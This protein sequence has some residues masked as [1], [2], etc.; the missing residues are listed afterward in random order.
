[1]ASLLTEQLKEQQTGIA[2]AVTQPLWLQASAFAAAAHAPE[3]HFHD[4]PFPEVA[5][6]YSQATRVA[7]TLAG[8]YHV[9]DPHVLAT[10]LLHNVLAK[11]TVSFDDLSEV[12]GHLV[13]LR[14]QRLT[15][16]E[17]GDEEVDLRRLYVC[18]WQTR[19]VRLADAADRLEDETEPLEFRIQEA[20]RMLPL[21]YGDDHCILRAQRHLTSLLE[22]ARVEASV[23]SGFTPRSAGAP[24][25][26]ASKYPYLAA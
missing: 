3:V 25:D 1:M 8:L 9:E 26:A 6:S 10:A 5:D 24:A 23:M 20:E 15:R 16:E 12:F 22:N 4:M 2:A 19:I 21:A 7:L 18:D 14:V 11:T 13:A 17:G